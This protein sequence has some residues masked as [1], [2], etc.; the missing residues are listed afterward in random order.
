MRFHHF[1]AGLVVLAIAVILGATVAL[2]ERSTQPSMFID[3]AGQP[4]VSRVQ[5]IK[6]D[7]TVARFDRVT[8]ELMEYNGDLTKLNV[9]GQWVPLVKPVRSGTAAVLE[10][11][12]PES[13]VPGATFLVDAVTGQTWVLRRRQADVRWEEIPILHR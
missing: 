1:S 2:A 12:Q 5:V 7:N 13:A 3:D 9:P 6:F 11:Q 10:I 8:G 4:L